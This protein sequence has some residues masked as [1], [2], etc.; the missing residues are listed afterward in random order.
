VR[1]IQRGFAVCRGR[2]VRDLGLEQQAIDSLQKVLELTPDQPG[3]MIMLAT[4]QFSLGKQQSH[5]GFRARARI[6][7]TS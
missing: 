6:N 4:V 3:V 7:L 2:I 1:G 5:A